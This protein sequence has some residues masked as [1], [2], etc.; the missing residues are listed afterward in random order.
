MDRRILALASLAISITSLLSLFY[1][2]RCPD[3]DPDDYREGDCVTARGLITKAYFTGK[4]CIY[5]LLLPSGNYVKLVDFDSKDCR[6][7]YIC[8]EGRVQIWKGEP[9]VVILKYC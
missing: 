7:G 8:A 5:R 4:L 3:F 1:F 6:Q 9:E 2:F